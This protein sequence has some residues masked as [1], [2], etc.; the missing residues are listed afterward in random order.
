MLVF[1]V[2][3][4]YAVVVSVL[5]EHTAFLPEDKCGNVWVN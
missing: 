5:E 2:V 1:W 4:V 3:T